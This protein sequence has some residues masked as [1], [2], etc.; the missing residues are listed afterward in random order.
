MLYGIF[1]TYITEKSVPVV[2]MTLYKRDLEIS[3]G[4]KP[5]RT[6]DLSVIYA[7]TTSIVQLPPTD[8]SFTEKIPNPMKKARNFGIQHDGAIGNPI[9]S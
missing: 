5:P 3:L 8:W 1:L 2:G 6:C 9:V 7:Q 4:I